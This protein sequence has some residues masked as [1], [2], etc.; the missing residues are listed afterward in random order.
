M[1]LPDWTR[2]PLVHFLFAGTL[3]YAFFSFGD[4]EVDPSSR[5]ISIDRKAEAQLALQFEQTMSRP[6]TDAELDAQ[7]NQYVR[8]E[9]LY[10]EAL[11]MGLD[12]GDAVVRRRMAQKMDMLASAQAETA[13]PSNQVLRKWYKD[14]LARFAPE[15]R[16]SFAQLWFKREAG[17]RSAMRKLA[18]PEG[19][20]A[21]GQDI[22]LPREVA[23]ED[24][25]EIAARF[26]KRFLGALDRIDADGKWHGPIASGF[27]WHLVRLD[28]REVGKAPPYEDVREEVE[29]DWRSSTIAARKQKAFKLLRDSYRIEIAR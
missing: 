13:Q 12:R 18:R 17:A 26:G 1:K 11:R 25:G 22:S 24:R 6:P 4:E 20:K 15:T 3:I 7:I 14:H 27:G 16:Y 5:V 23:G 28:R 21:L 10:R 29:N 2:E 19:W 9:V 8:D